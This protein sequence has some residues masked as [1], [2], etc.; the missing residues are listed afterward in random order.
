MVVAQKAVAKAEG[1]I[2]DLNSIE[3]SPF[4]A[5]WAARWGK[6]PRLIELILRQSRRIVVW[7]VG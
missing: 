7:T 2:V 4:A 3:P 5:Q 1:A 6:D